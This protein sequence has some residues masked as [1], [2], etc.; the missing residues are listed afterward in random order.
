MSGW[1]MRDGT[2]S[3]GSYSIIRNIRGFSVWFRSGEKYGVLHREV[4]TLSKAKEL[5]ETH[6]AREAYLLKQLDA[7]ALK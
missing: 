4:E 1:T 7:V 3:K 6:A 5:A 2:V